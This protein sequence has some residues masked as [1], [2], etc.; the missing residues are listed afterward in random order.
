MIHESDSPR[1]DF[2]L[3]AMTPEELE[4][5]RYHLGEAN[6]ADGSQIWF[7]ESVVVMGLAPRA[8]VQD[9]LRGRSIWVSV[10]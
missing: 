5:S 1:V 9:Q 7:P 2:D 8:N 3:E 6:G 10:Q 4:L